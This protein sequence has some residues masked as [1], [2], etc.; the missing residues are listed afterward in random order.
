[1]SLKRGIIF[2]LLFLVPL[3]LLAGCQEKYYTLTVN[4]LGKGQVRIFPPQEG[5][6]ENYQVRLRAE[7]ASD[8][9]FAYWAGAGFNG[10]NQKELELLMTGDTMINAN[11]GKV[12][13]HDRFN[14]SSRIWYTG[15]TGDYHYQLTPDKKYSITILGERQVWWVQPTLAEFPTGDFYIEVKQESTSSNYAEGGINFNIQDQDN[16]CTFLI[17]TDG[18]YTIQAYI[19]HQWFPLYDWQYSHLIEPEGVNT[20]AVLKRGDL[21]T[22]YINGSYLAEQ[23]F[24]ENNGVVGLQ[25]G[26]S[27]DVPVTV[28]FDDFKLLELPELEN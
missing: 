3:L 27:Q 19:N 16:Y 24:E 20:L 21:F 6:P 25:A 8:W 10:Y 2:T 17:N 9:E 11:F 22:F 13:L 23:E 7:P 4:E 5:Y 15:K 18:Y 14:T 1:M 26:S 12:I 28:L